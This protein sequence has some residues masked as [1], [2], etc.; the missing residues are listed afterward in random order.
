M[1]CERGQATIE[2]AGVV[3]VASL[4]L[5]A[6]V[7]LAPQPDGRSLGASLAHSIACAARDGCEDDRAALRAAYGEHDAGLVRGH[8]PGLVYE[9]GTH[10]V[11]V[12]FR[13]CRRPSCSDAADDRDADLHRSGSGARATVFSRVIHRAGETFIQ[14]WLYYPDSSTTSPGPLSLR[15]LDDGILPVHHRDDWESYQVRIDTAGRVSARVSSHRSYQGCKLRRCRD[16]WAPPT[17]WS[18]VSRGSHAGHFPTRAS[19]S[20]AAGADQPLHPGP[21]LRERTTSAPGVRLVPLETLDKDS[22]RPLDAGIAPPWKK[23]VYLDP[24]SDSTA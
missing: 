4:A 12:D 10:S 2:W 21:G 11:P 23:R 15:A 18:R 5:G 16:R 20:P 14:Y 22:Y 17:G 1:R 24:L 7:A 19:Q 3:L 6:L 13:D 8:L 9:P